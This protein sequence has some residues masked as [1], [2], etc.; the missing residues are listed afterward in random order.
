MGNTEIKKLAWIPELPGN[1]ISQVRTVIVLT[2][3]DKM[4][5][6]STDPFL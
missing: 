3:S 1:A 6:N 2:N 4:R 5:V